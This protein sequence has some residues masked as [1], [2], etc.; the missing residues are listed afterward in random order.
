ML[1]LKAF[2][3]KKFG[4]LDFKEAYDTVWRDGLVY[5]SYC[6]RKSMVNSFV[7]LRTCI[8]RLNVVLKGLGHDRSQCLFTKII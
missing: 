1:I 7:L 8:K 6:H 2:A 3:D 5:T 4:F